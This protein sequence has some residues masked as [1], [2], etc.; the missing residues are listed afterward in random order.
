[1]SSLELSEASLDRKSRR[2]TKVDTSL[3]R[4]SRRVTKVDTSLDRQSRRVTKIQLDSELQV[5]ISLRHHTLCMFSLKSAKCCGL[6]LWR[7][8]SSLSPFRSRHICSMIRDRP[9]CRCD[10]PEFEGGYWCCWWRSYFKKGA[11]IY[12]K[13]NY[14]RKCIYRRSQDSSPVQTVSHASS[15]SA[16]SARDQLFILLPG[17]A[18]P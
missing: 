17:A 18:M 9:C 8:F 12:Y 11:G 4:Q 6:F 15:C 3:D 10:G 7:G 1:M 5:D 14:V 13:T 16:R 2:V